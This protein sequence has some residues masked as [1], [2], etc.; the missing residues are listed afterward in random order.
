MY[1]RAG[2]HTPR[3]TISVRRPVR[4]TKRRRLLIAVAAAGLGS[5][6]VALGSVTTTAPAL[7]AAQPHSFAFR[8]TDGTDAGNTAT[9]TVTNT[10]T[11]SPCSDPVQVQL[12]D[13]SVSGATVTVQYTIVGSC[14]TDRLHIHENLVT[15]PHAGSDPI[16]QVN[17][18]FDI[19]KGSPTQQS[20]PLLDS[21]DGKCWVQ[22]DYST[23]RERKGFFVPTVNCITPTSSTPP[24]STST[25]P[26]STS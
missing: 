15:G 17:Y 14:G 7:A 1:I 2:Q 13:H 6:L 20:V 8:A 10:A 24:P 25:P 4:G 21:A 23:A 12:G 16:H 26:P 18:D 19:G 9:G 22:V 11:L 5:G 3:R